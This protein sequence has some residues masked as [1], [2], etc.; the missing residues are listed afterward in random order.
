MSKGYRSPRNVI[1]SR[2]ERGGIFTLDDVAH[3]CHL[4]HNTAERAL[5]SLIRLQRVVRN[6]DHYEV[7]DCYKVAWSLASWGLLGERLLERMENRVDEHP[8]YYHWASVWATHAGCKIHAP[9]K[10]Q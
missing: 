7:A 1:F 6:G 10:T 5:N 8:K 3:V 4:D 9:D 2:M